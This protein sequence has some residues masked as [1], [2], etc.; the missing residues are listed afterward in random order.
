M[1]NQQVL[2]KRFDNLRNTFLC[3]CC[4]SIFV[5]FFST[6]C[7]F[8]QQFLAICYITTHHNKK[9]TNLSCKIPDKRRTLARTQE[10]PA[11]TVQFVD[12]VKTFLLYLL[13]VNKTLRPSAAPPLLTSKAAGQIY[14]FNVLS[15]CHFLFSFFKSINVDFKWVYKAKNTKT[16]KYSN[17]TCLAL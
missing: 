12:I 10:T 1:Y 5:G 14:Q 3:P 9:Q 7:K 6:N 4:V 17:H 2:N 15:L 13:K 11:M 16:E 8:S